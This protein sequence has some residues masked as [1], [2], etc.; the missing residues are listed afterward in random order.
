MNGISKREKRDVVRA[1]KGQSLVEM[2]LLAPLLLLLFIG[3]LEVGWAIRGYVTLVNADREATRF[4]ARGQYLDWGERNA[5]SVGY[6][7]VLTHTFE[8]LSNQLGFDVTSSSPNGTLIISHYLVDTGKPCA[9][10]PCNDHCAHPPCDCSAP[11]KREPDYTGDDWLLYPEKPGYSYFRK[12]YGISRTTWLSPTQL[13]AQ[14]KEENDAFNCALGANDPSAPLAVNSVVA[15]ETFYNQKQLAGVPIVSNYFTDPVP[16]YAHTMMR[17]NPGTR[18]QDDTSQGRGCELYPIAINLS[19]A[20][21]STAPG[22][23]FDNIRSGYGTG[24]FGWLRWTDDSQVET[25][26]PNSEQYLEAEF[27]NPRLADNDYREPTARDSDDTAINGGDYVWG[28]TGQDAGA[29]DLLA[30]H[31][32][33]VIPVPVWDSAG[34]TGSNGQYHIV[35]FA[36]FL[37]TEV[38]RTGNPKH[39]AGVFQGRDDGMCPGNNH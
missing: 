38:D 10:P 32:G 23:P 20:N 15:V 24:N 3:V 22:T 19:Q 28:L 11:D 39:I 27:E 25:Y 12:T 13:V 9:D 34:G 8:S 2:T 21:E 14:L 26:N 31:V 4:S 35:G 36:W 17:I 6:D 18:G 33:E 16:L 7:S 29:W 30:E 5:N 37:L 1:N